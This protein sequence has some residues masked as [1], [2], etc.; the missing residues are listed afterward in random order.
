MHKFYK[1]SGVVK[2]YQVYEKYQEVEKI[3]KCWLLKDLFYWRL[4]IIK[5]S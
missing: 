3:S 2:K 5:K 4:T 1:V